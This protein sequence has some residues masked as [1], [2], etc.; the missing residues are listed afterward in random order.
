[1]QRSIRGVSD[2]PPPL[3]TWTVIVMERVMFVLDGYPSSALRWRLL[4]LD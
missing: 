1:M 2:G 4:R 3:H